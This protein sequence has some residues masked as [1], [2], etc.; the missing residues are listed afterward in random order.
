MKTIVFIVILVFCIQ[1]IVSQDVTEIWT[2]FTG[3][4]N[5]NDIELPDDFHE[6]LA[7]NLIAT[8]GSMIWNNE[9]IDKHN[10]SVSYIPTNYF[11]DE[12]SK[13]IIDD[14]YITSINSKL[15][16]F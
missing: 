1:N 12:V 8:S 5:S 6:L 4:W 7:F 16:T 15:K 14:P 13:L 2:N 9:L 3:F 10:A 11:S